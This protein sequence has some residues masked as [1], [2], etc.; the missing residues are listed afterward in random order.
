MLGGWWDELEKMDSYQ[1]DP[2]KN[3]EVHARHN[4]IKVEANFLKDLDLFST[5]FLQ[6]DL[7]FVHHFSACFFQTPQSNRQPPT[8][9][10]PPSKTLLHGPPCH[11]RIQPT[12]AAVR[13]A[14]PLWPRSKRALENLEATVDG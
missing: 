8:P 9:L 13:K 14:M 2:E 11:L 3:T 5:R 1:K 7:S 6:K 4:W 12:P 10:N